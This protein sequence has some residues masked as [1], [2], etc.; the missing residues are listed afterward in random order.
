M[1]KI[2]KT[3]LRTIFLIEGVLLFNI[4]DVTDDNTSF[5]SKYKYVISAILLL[6][7][8]LINSFI[9]KRKK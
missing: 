4:Y 7:G 1:I 2:N 3:L 8:V 9:N 5:V 6:L